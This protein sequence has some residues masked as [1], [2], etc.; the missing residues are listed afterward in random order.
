MDN[1]SHYDKCDYQGRP[2]GP[3]RLKVGRSGPGP[4]LAGKS[5]MSICCARVLCMRK[6]LLFLCLCACGKS[7]EKTK[8][9]KERKEKT[10]C[11]LLLVTIT[12]P[13]NEKLSKECACVSLCMCASTG[14]R[15][16]PGP[17]GPKVGL[18]Y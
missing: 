10:V 17:S 7:Q 16:G 1:D 15:S 3:D 4:S 6:V 9:G 12:I 5:L 14:H 13:T 11:C 2:G 18:D 8:W